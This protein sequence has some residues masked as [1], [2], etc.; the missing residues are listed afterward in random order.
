MSSG[1]IRVMSRPSK[2]T[3]P[4]R[5]RTSPETVRRSEVL[6]APFAPSTAMMLPCGTVRETPSTAR[7][8]P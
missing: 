5:A 1:A 2:R 6:P 8:G 7:T 3:R 4:E